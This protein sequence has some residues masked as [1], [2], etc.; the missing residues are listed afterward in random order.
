MVGLQKSFFQGVLRPSA[1]A[2]GPVQQT[3]GVEGVVNPAAPAWVKGEPHLGPACGNGLANL[4]LLLGGG[5]VL[6]RQVLAQVLP[7]G[8][9]LRVQ[10]KGLKVQIGLHLAVQALQSFFKRAQ[11][12]GAPWASNV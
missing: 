1:L 8:T 7:A 9:H 11:T 6:L 3:V 12:H 5:A 4:R 2:F 10:L